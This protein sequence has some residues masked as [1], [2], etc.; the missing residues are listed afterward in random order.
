MYLSK[1]LSLKEV[2]KS[3]TAK[4]LGISNRPTIGHME[5]LKAIAEHVFQPLRDYFGKPIAITSGYR[6]SALNKAI[7]GSSKSQHC[8]GQALDLDG[9]VYGSPTNKEL[10]DRIK[11]HL[12]FDQLIWEFGDKDNPDWVHVSYKKEG[13]NRHQVL[14]AIREDGKTKYIPF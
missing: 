8:S 11:D 2:T 9:D 10:F 14:K 13:N 7:G 5:N 4:R 6:S 12:E 3:V 1:N